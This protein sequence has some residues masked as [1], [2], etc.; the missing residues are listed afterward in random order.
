MTHPALSKLTSGARRIGAPLPGAV[1]RILDADLQLDRL[2][3][4]RDAA[5]RD[6][7]GA[8]G[9]EDYADLLAAYGERLARAEAIRP[10]A[11][12]LRDRRE[13]LAYDAAIRHADEVV[14]TFGERL[15]PS[16]R[17]L[18]ASAPAVPPTTSPEAASIAALHPDAH[19][20]YYEAVPA[21]DLLTG[22]ALALGPLLG[23]VPAGPNPV[24]SNVLSANDV[25]RLALL[26]VPRTAS[27][28]VLASLLYAVRGLRV[29]GTAQFSRDVPVVWFA[30]AH[31]LG[32]AVRWPTTSD[33]VDATVRR[34]LD[35]VTKRS[36]D[37]NLAEILGLPPGV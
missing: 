31:A 28:H 17:T 2:D 16:V 4:A 6:L 36:R 35:A 27:R 19:R 7:A 29:T 37:E 21:A 33:D 23:V 20:A 8:I 3:A 25:A 15:A 10:V 32:A 24:G 14:A 5:L 18:N 1:T 26:D 12:R 34:V 13:G 9:T 30:R 22:A 11:Q